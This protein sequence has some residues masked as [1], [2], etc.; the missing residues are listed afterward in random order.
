MLI[1]AAVSDPTTLQ[2]TEPPESFGAR[3]RIQTA[4]H[5]DRPFCFIGVR[6]P[7][8]VRSASL[9]LPRL[10][11]TLGLESAWRPVSGRRRTV[12]VSCVKRKRP[13]AC[14]ARDLYT[15][16]LFRGMRRYADA[17]ADR[18]S[19]SSPAHGPT[20]RSTIAHGTRCSVA[21]RDEFR[22]F[23]RQRRKIGEDSRPPWHL[24]RGRR[25]RFLA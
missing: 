22:G 19:V 7:L 1:V 12:L 24:Q 25:V 10:N 18:W 9:C 11:R 20:A 3:C 15:S 13:Y 23:P 8:R 4:G 14:E 6:R 16:P 5:L 21:S 2:R 17:N